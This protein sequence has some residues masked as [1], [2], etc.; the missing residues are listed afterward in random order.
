MRDGDKRND[1]RGSSPLRLDRPNGILAIGLSDREVRAVPGRLFGVLGRTVRNS[2]LRAVT[3]DALS[4]VMVILS[5]LV[6]RDFDAVDVAC[7]LQAAGFRGRYFAYTQ[8]FADADV[9]QEEIAA[10]APGLSF[11]LLHI[12]APPR[13]VT[14]AAAAEVM[15]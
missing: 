4:G 5:P 10:M 14:G 8:S 12:G 15:A 6:A 7:R 1:G 9:V 2:C 13:V 3:D 11:E